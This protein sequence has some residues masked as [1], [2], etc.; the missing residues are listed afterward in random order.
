MSRH[1][2]GIAPEEDPALLAGVREALAHM[3]WLA[4]QSEGEV[5]AAEPDLAVRG[6]PLPPAL[7]DPSAVFGGRTAPLPAGDAPGLVRS[8]ETQQALA[9]AAREAGRITP[10]IEERMRRDRKAAEDEMDGDG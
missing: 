8:A 1:K 10:Q 7:R 3:G 9:R 6:T 5:A 2:P 4:P